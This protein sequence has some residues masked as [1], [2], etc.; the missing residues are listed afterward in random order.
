MLSESGKAIGRNPIISKLGFKCPGKPG[1]PGETDRMQFN[2]VKVFSATKARDRNEL[3]EK[4]T[5]WLRERSGIRVIDKSVV[6]SSDASFHC[7]TIVLFYQ[8]GE[9]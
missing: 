2:S 9:E 6:L 4:I 3:G 8:D 1:G 7:L 5:G